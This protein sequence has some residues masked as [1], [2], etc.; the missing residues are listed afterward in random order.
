MLYEVIT[1]G[2]RHVFLAVIVDLWSRTIIGWAL[3][4]KLNA[5]LSVAALYQALRQRKPK[6]GLIL[7]V[8]TSYSI[9]YTKLYD[10]GEF[11]FW[12]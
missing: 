6:P 3:H 8:I 4:E 5:E 9:H 11:P 10:V 1:H 7:H 2:R 12:P